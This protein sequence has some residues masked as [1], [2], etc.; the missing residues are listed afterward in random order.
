MRLPMLRTSKRRKNLCNT[1]SAKEGVACHVHVLKGGKALQV[2]L[3]LG[4]DG[5]YQKV[6]AD[7]DA[8]DGDGS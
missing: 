2:L 8:F 5:W 4:Y 3:K 6:A 1:G 7:V